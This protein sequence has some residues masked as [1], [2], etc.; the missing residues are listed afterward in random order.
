MDTGIF[1]SIFL[2]LL[3]SSLLIGLITCFLCTLAIQREVRL[4]RCDVLPPE[5][6]ARGW[7]R[8]TPVSLR[9]IIKRSLAMA[10]WTFVAIGLP[11]TLILWCIVQGGTISGLAFVIFKSAWAALCAVPVFVL[12]FFAALSTADVGTARGG[13][14]T[15]GAAAAAAAP[16][17]L[18][19]LPPSAQH[20]SA[21][22]VLREP[23]A[24]NAT[25]LGVRGA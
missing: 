12:V 9:G 22:T 13:I 4:R 10:V 11:T 2:D 6:L 23:L 1:S 18:T 16:T 20:A 14:P 25:D 8:C 17:I 7:W 3:V 15:V 24:A 5:R 19:P 21:P